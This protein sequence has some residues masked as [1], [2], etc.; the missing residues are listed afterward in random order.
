MTEDHTA[1]LVNQLQRGL[2]VLGNAGETV[3]TEGATTNGMGKSTA[4]T[5]TT[6]T[7]TITTRSRSSSSGSGDAA[8][9]AAASIALRQARLG[10]RNRGSSCGV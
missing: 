2:L 7:A 9:A 3:A 8:A 10:R 5:T 1:D 6:I 4:M